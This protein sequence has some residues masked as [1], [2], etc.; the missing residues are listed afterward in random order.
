MFFFSY[1]QGTD[2]QRSLEEAFLNTGMKHDFMFRIA[3]QNYTLNFLPMS[4][5]SQTNV[6]YG[7]TRKV[8]R[9]PAKLISK[10]DIRELVRY[11][12]NILIV[13]E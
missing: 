3:N 7:T 6:T 8:R 11:L 4:D 10:D 9:R 13:Y 1:S 2:L 12:R 5:M